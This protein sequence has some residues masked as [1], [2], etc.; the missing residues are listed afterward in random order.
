[1]EQIGLSVDDVNFLRENYPGLTY[2]ETDNTIRGILSF[3]RSYKEKPVKGKYSIEFKLE[4]DSNSILPKV[5]ETKGKIL[6]I[7]K[8]KGISKADVHLNNEQG[9]MCLIFPIK[10]KEFYP[11]GFDFKLF[12]NHLETHLYWVTFY[13]RYNQ[14]PWK[15]EPHNPEDALVKAVKENKLYRKNLQVYLE[16]KEKRNYSRSEFRRFLKEKKLL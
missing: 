11:D 12:L 10:E 2:T 3:Y 16:N 6:S 1:M 7:A 5:R 9:E 8:R 4:H 15:D 14:K 13:D